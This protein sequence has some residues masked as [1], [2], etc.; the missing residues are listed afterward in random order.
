MSNKFHLIMMNHLISV[1]FRIMGSFMYQPQDLQCRIH[2]LFHVSPV[3]EANQFYDFTQKWDLATLFSRGRN[4]G[5]TSLGMS[6]MNKYLAS[7]MLFTR[8]TITMTLLWVISIPHLEQQHH[9]LNCSHG[10][11]T[12]PPHPGNH[13]SWKNVVIITLLMLV[14]GL[15]I[16][17][18]M[19]NNCNCST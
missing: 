1:A 5:F 19:S 3:T 8:S 7:K 15:W 13:G 9:L 4:L 2:G 10:Y 14:F 17:L 6:G 12:I 18:C 11:E 16:R